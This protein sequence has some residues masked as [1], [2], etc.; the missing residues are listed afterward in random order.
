MIKTRPLI[1]DQA[2]I[3][4]LGLIIL[5]VFLIGGIGFAGYRVYEANSQD[6]VLEDEVDEDF[7][8]I[9]AESEAAVSED[10]EGLESEDQEQDATS[11]EEV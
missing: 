10:E 2:G 5:A 3:A 1:K 4:H 6:V 7:D 8:A 9:E 11:E